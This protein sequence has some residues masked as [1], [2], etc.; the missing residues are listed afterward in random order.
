MVGRGPRSEMDGLG[1]LTSRWE[2]L[3][4]AFRANMSQKSCGLLFSN[5]DE[6][7]QPCASCTELIHSTSPASL[8]SLTRESRQLFH[9]CKPPSPPP[10]QFIVVTFHVFLCLCYPSVLFVVQIQSLLFALMPPHRLLLLPL[11]GFPTSNPPCVH[12]LEK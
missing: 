12:F 1:C 10:G 4:A 8:I 2:Q 6:C 9:M 5:S 11:L 7:A 3:A